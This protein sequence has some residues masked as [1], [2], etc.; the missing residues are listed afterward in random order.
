MCKGDRVL[1]FVGVGSNLDDPDLQ[2]RVALGALGQLPQT[3][4]LRHSTLLRNPAMGPQ[5]QP[6]FVN[7]VAELDTGL[8]PLELLDALLAMEQKQGRDRSAGVRWG[9]RRI[10]LDL[11]LYG[12]L[13]LN[14]PRLTLPHPGIESRNF[15]LLPLLEIA[16]DLLIPGLGS[17]RHLAANWSA[18]EPKPWGIP[19][20]SP[21]KAP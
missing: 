1:A 14:L 21:L 5:P 15:V 6:D 7:A 20:T 17:V 8:R 19:A 11:L 4:C 18:R 13:S 16:P 10:D 9:P 2:V 12:D 3:R